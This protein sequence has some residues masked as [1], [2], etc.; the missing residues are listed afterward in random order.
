[1]ARLSEDMMAPDDTRLLTIQT[2]A[3]YSG[4]LTGKTS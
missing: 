4:Y 3:S 1:M 2:K